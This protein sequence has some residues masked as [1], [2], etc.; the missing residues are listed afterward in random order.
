MSLILDALN[1]S[2]TEQGEVPNLATIHGDEAAPSGGG[3]RPWPLLLALLVAVG[4]IAW[5]V[6]DRLPGTAEPEPGATVTAQALPAVEPAPA[7]KSVPAVKPAPATKPAP[8]AAPAKE[9]VEQKPA[10]VAPGPAPGPNLAQRAA[11]DPTPEVQVKADPA[12]RALYAGGGEAAPES[13]LASTPTA[14]PVPASQSQA[15]SAPSAGA[16]T[17]AASQ[18]QA[19]DLEKLIQQAETELEDARL[20]EHPSPFIN[21]LSQQAKDGIPTI[22]YERHEY[23][24]TPGQSRVVLNGQSLAKGGKTKGVRVEEILPDSVVLNYQGT[25]FRLRALNSWVNL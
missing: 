2:R 19:I 17:A 15:R 23:S 24:G 21:S 9:G 22:F 16:S 3:N 5:L 25:S 14:E 18:E 6:L 4:I 20:A 8:T 12:V 13:G 7:A 11:V 1:R 10:T